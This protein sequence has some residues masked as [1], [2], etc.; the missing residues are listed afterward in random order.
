MDERTFADILAAHADKL[1]QGQRGTATL[2]DVSAEQLAAL[3]PLMRLAERV[4]GTLA[5][6]QPNPT[7]VHQLSQ[8]LISTASQSRKAMTQR[9]RNAILIVAAA[10]GSVVS[11]ASAVGII[12]FLIRHRAR[13]QSEQV[14]SVR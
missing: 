12:I 9:T 7:F 13:V 10:L 5:P 8:Q 6:V 3:A 4:Q 14:V 11:V 1:N 2:Q